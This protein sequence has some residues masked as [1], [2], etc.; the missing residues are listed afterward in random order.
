MGGAASVDI[1]VGLVLAVT[2][3]YLAG[4]AFQVGVVTQGSV[5]TAVFLVGLESQGSVGTA[6]Y[7]AGQEFRVTLAQ[8]FR[9]TL[10][11]E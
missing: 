8:E 5:G 4:Q 10:A 2:V 7:L 1:P 6:V 9:V 11:Q 3:V